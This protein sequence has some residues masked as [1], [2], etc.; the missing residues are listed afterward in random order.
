MTVQSHFT[1]ERDFAIVLCSDPQRQ[2]SPSLYLNIT[3]P[4]SFCGDLQR[5]FSPSLYLNITLPLSFAVISRD[6][7]APLYIWTQLCHCPLQWSLETIQSLYLNITLPLSFAVISRDS[8][9]P[10]YIWTCRTLPLS[11]AVISRDNSAPF[12]F[13]RHF[14]IVLCS[15]I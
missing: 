10:L 9:A 4:L 8:S 11:F 7:S 13:D 6:N 3:L 12:T 5:Q 14:T 15:D 1:F 2:F